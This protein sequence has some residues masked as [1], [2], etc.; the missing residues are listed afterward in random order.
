M[1]SKATSRGVLLTLGITFISLIVLSFA[2]LIL[3]NAENSDLRLTELSSVD[4]LYTLSSSLERSIFRSYY[5]LTGINLTISNT[6]VTIVKDTERRLGAPNYYQPPDIFDPAIFGMKASDVFV[7]YL[8]RSLTYG[9]VSVANPIGYSL[10]HHLGLYFYYPAI[11]FNDNLVPDVLKTTLVYF[12]SDDTV[13]L[14]K[15]YNFRHSQQTA[16]YCCL[17]VGNMSNLYPINSTHQ[18]YL[19]GTNLHNL[20]EIKI[21]VQHPTR[22]PYI[23]WSN[24]ATR[25]LNQAQNGYNPNPEDGDVKLKISIQAENAQGP[26]LPATLSPYYEVQADAIVNRTGTAISQ[27]IFLDNLTYDPLVSG[28][29]YNFIYGETPPATASK[30][31]P[32]ILFYDSKTETGT[33]VTLASNILYLIQYDNPIRWEVTLVYEFG[34]LEVYT[35]ETVTATLDALNMSRRQR[36]ARFK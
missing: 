34:P 4:R 32:L 35:T 22:C 21:K 5:S 33:D 2:T 10:L 30:E 24:S 36:P 19:L 23:N 12:Y 18:V 9:I 1:T 14:T 31:R 11:I 26:C 27:I 13:N 6:T 20:T 25:R 7:D 17:E 3:R 8:A 15:D 29:G 28:G 16:Q